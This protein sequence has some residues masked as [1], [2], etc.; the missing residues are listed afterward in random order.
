M[1]TAVGVEGEG[2]ERERGGNGAKA[3]T[4]WKGTSNPAQKLY[5]HCLCIYPHTF[6]CYEGLLYSITYHRSFFFCVDFIYV[7]YARERKFA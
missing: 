1:T 5:M 4:R 2:G 6:K 7:N 3:E